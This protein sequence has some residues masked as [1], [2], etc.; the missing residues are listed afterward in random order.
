MLSLNRDSLFL[1]N[2]YAFSFFLT[3]C[4]DWTSNMMFD[5]NYKSGYPCLVTSLRGK[6]LN[7]SPVNTII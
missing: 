3:Y 4:T 1:S 7:I 5:K 6:V 2:L